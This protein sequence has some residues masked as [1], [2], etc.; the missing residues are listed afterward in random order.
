MRRG[1]VSHR[2]LIWLNLNTFRFNGPQQVTACQKLCILWQFTAAKKAELSYFLSA[3]AAAWE[4][5]HYKLV[6]RYIMLRPYIYINAGT[7]L[8]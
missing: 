1:G 5:V 4:A 8:Y 2:S 7:L 6:A 3:S